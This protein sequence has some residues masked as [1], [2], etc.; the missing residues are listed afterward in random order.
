MGGG[1]GGFG[2]VIDA[3]MSC[4]GSSPCDTF[5]NASSLDLSKDND[6]PVSRIAN[7][8]LWTFQL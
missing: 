7:V 5:G 4:C 6:S 8:E 3:D 2:F 1:G